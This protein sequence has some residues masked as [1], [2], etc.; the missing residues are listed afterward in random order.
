MKKKIFFTIICL[1]IISTILFGLIKTSNNDL[2]LFAQTQNQT[3]SLIG[4]SE[5][6]AKADEMK[7]NFSI[8]TR[9]DTIIEG[10]NKIMNILENLKSKVNEI[11]NNS[12]VFV[13]Y[14][15]CY[16]ISEGGIC[17]YEFN[18][19]ISVKS[20]KLDKL[21][22]IILA[23][24]EAGVTSFHNAC[25]SIKNYENL[26]FEALNQAK[27]NAIQKAKSLYSNIELTKLTE[28][29]CYVTC[30]NEGENVKISAQ[31]L[32]NFTL[33]DA[34]I[35]NKETNEKE[36]LEKNIIDNNIID[37][38]TNS[39]VSQND[40]STNKIIDDNL[41]NVFDKNVTEPNNENLD[42]T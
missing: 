9:A 7:I 42:I 10:Q 27:E 28:K 15:S 8:Q 33:S 30:E 18:Y 36:A 1:L 5:I 14:S 34:I 17:G 13:N 6:F 24:G 20:Q 22:D 25:Y 29:A 39:N 12:N 32:A 11:D 31:I 37:N 23:S 2:T 26:Y 4:K 3:V 41:N 40:N 38:P 21:N 19:N 16:S 35:S